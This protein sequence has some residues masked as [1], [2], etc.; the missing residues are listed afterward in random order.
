MRFKAGDK[1]RVRNDLVAGNLYGNLGF[2][3]VMAQYLGKTARIIGISPCGNYNLNIDSSEWFWSEEM[4][5]PA[6][7]TKDNLRPGDVLAMRNGNV[8]MVQEDGC[9]SRVGAES[10]P[11]GLNNKSLNHDLTNGGAVGDCY[12]IMKVGRPQVVWEREEKTNEELHREMWSWLAENPEKQKSDW[13]DKEDVDALDECF[14]CEECNSH[15]EEC[16]LDSN[17]IG[18]G[19]SCGLYRIW[20]ISEDADVRRALAKVIAGLPWRSNEDN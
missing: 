1:V 13:F 17:V 12:D 5:E 15:C 18:C 4:L 10:C 19:K 7:F 2:F 14:A 11:F 3:E 16:P 9:I 6:E 20:M 8:L